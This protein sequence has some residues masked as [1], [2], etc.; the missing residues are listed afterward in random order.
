M[1]ID[2]GV[3]LGYLELKAPDQYVEIR[4]PLEFALNVLENRI[5]HVGQDCGK[6][7]VLFQFLL[8]REH[9]GILSGPHARVPGVELVNGFRIEIEAPI[10]HDILPEFE[11]SEFALVV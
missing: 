2:G 6:E 9:D 5:A 10:T 7:A 4:Y 1:L 11:S 8:P 3:G